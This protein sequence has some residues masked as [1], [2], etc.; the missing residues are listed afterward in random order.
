MALKK[1]LEAALRHSLAPELIDLVD[2]DGITGYVVSTKFQ[3][4]TALNR[5]K[6][7]Q[8]SL[9]DA[10]HPLLPGELRRVLLIVPLTPA[11]ARSYGLS[12]AV[13]HSSQRP[14]TKTEERVTT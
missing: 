12:G 11:E 1:K 4:M 5:Q 8:R 9:C 14:K 13:D 6:L 7:I 3:R 2:E 10:P